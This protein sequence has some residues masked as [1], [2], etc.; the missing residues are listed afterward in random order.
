MWYSI[1]VLLDRYIL[2]EIIPSTIIGFFLFSFG[3]I[4]GSL[5]EVAQLL[6]LKG[7]SIS[8][9][10]ILLI[11]L[12]LSFL[13]IT[14]P[15]SLLMG[16]LAGISRM[17][18]EREI[19]ALRTLAIP[20]TRLLRP[21]L[22]LGI[23]FFLL[24]LMTNM[25]ITP[26]ANLKIEKSLYEMA[27][28]K[29]E[30]EIRGGNFFEGIPKLTLYVGEKGKGLW[31]NLFIEIYTKKEER[32]I[33]ARKGKLVIDRAKRE[34]YFYL[35]DGEI[36][37][38]NIL[39]PE[40][41]SRSYF[42]RAVEKLKSSLVF[43]KL[44]I[45]ERP[46]EKTLPSILKK[47][48][49]G[50]ISP[51]KKRFLM[52]EIHT[53]IAFALAT[54]LFV[55]LG[56]FLSVNTKKGGT[57]FGF[58][59]SIITVVLYYVAY[60][61][62]RS[63]VE[64]GKLPASIGL[65]IPNFLIIFFILSLLPRIKGSLNPARRGKTLPISIPLK[66]REI[67]VEFP[68]LLIRPFSA[69]D[70]Y[71][72]SN[73]SKVFLIAFS[74]LYIISLLIS[75]FEL[76]DDLFE[77]KRAFIYI[78]KYLY[79]FSPQIFYYILPLTI[80]VSLI[81]TISLFH[82]KGEI[83]GIKSGGISLFRFSIPLLT[84][85]LLISFISYGIQEKVLPI[86]NRKAEAVKS[87]IKGRKPMT[88][89]R[90]SRRWIFTKGKIFHYLHYDE[91]EKTF[92]DLTFISTGKDFSMEKVI[93]ARKALWRGGKW[94][95]KGIW[96]RDFISGDGKFEQADTMRLDIGEPPSF[97]VREIKPPDEMSIGELNN[98]IKEMES[99]GFRTDRLKVELETKGSFPMAAFIMAF[100]AIPIG[101]ILGTKGTTIGIGLSLALAGI[102]WSF[103]GVFKSLGEAM[104]LSPTLAAWTANIIFLLIGLILFTF[105]RT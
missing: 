101:L 69:I 104:I 56:L 30:R 16:V 22:A 4:M 59:L 68:R 61:G 88:H 76:I 84:F 38:Y 44:K 70:R 90:V 12:T 102:Y 103:L 78:L 105:V 35:E 37:S 87:F 36:H 28:S 63:F 41:Y 80:L 86:S 98:Y 74:A 39:K 49:E 91:R 53:R 73:L 6:V 58:A 77:N 48:K 93:H 13:P 32:L 14:I 71:A 25:Y 81:V 33:F 85:S 66:S 2:K 10:G 26:S 65:W 55:I 47:L 1:F 75:F 45:G 15:M 64:Q 96:F 31:E 17:S 54:F 60:S 7:A 5:L 42:K 23:F 40:E 62:G 52:M 72:L 83:T 99:D 92:Y 19:L 57:G 21:V 50:E 100:L 89:Y 34:A 67:E 18:A 51:L 8:E 95:L 97:F 94:I 11:N 43:P 46:R 79:F 82:R 3:L 27:I 20:T 29:T 24:N 9:I